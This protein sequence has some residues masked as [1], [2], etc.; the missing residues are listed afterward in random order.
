MVD[1]DKHACHQLA[2]N[3]YKNG[4]WPEDYITWEFLSNHPRA[5]ESGYLYIN[6]LKTPTTSTG[7][8]GWLY[9][10]PPFMTAWSP[11]ERKSTSCRLLSCEN[12]HG[13]LDCHLK[14]L[15]GNS[16]MTPF[17]HLYSFICTGNPCCSRTS[18]MTGVGLISP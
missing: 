2:E 8:W 15:W 12:W 4:Q 10:G 5:M 1:M 3:G 18:T 13:I 6:W 7:L 17:P 14:Q 9:A 11:H 16:G